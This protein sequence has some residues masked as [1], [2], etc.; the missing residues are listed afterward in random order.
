MF[1]LDR[2]EL[3]FSFPDVH[4]CAIMR[5]HFRGA[6]LCDERHLPLSFINGRF[7]LAYPGRTVV[8]LRPDLFQE[9]R[10]LSSRYPFAIVMFVNGLNILTG[11]VSDEMV[12]SPQ[13][14]LVSPPQGA[15]DGYFF[16]GEVHPFRAMNNCHPNG[17]RLEIRV[18]PMRKQAF[19][20]FV[21]EK[22]KIKCG[23]EFGPVIRGMTLSHGGDRQCEPLYEDLLSLGDWDRMRG[24]SA[25]IWLNGRQSRDLEEDDFGNL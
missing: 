12:R 2:N 1:D 19:N 8:H 17:T 20:G 10:P 14:Y 7:V 15:V 4:A 3:V 18:F 9:N 21:P 24:K 23:D 11:E 16:A 5:I 6:D 25:L 22:I 13:N